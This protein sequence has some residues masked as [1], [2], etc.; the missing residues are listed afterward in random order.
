MQCAGS[1]H[2]QQHCQN[3]IKK[4][5]LED[6]LQ[7]DEIDEDQKR[8][9]LLYSASKTVPVIVKQCGKNYDEAAKSKT[10]G[11]SF[12]AKKNYALALA[13]YNSGIIKCPQDEG[14]AIKYICYHAITVNSHNCTICKFNITQRAN[15]QQLKSMTV[16]HF[17]K[18][19]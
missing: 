1:A 10:D 7:F 16:R 14:M 8:V 18:F 4:L 15:N 12:F 17:C 9:K 13:T 6:I 2:F 19:N 5:K 11:N 3:V